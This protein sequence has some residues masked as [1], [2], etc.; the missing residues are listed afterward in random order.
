MLVQEDAIPTPE[1]GGT[2]VA[3][4]VSPVVSQLQIRKPRRGGT[5][6]SSMNDALGLIGIA[7]DRCRPS[8]ACVYVG[9]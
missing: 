9:G 2:D 8:G 1:G 6:Q 4:G 5:H 3:Q 7:Q